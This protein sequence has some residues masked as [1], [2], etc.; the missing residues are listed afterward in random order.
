MAS[1]ITKAALRG[2]TCLSV[3]AALSTAA[4]AQDVPTTQEDGTPVPTAATSSADTGAIVVTGTRIRSANLESTNPVTVV[5]GE[6]FFQTGQV[7]VGDVLNELPQLRNT[8]SQQK[9]DSLLGYAR[10]EPR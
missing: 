3:F 10:L 8:F 7:S 5:T 1:T 9:L 2:A 6:Q 4:Y